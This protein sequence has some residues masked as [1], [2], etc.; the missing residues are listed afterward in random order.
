MRHDGGSLEYATRV[1]LA[2]WVAPHTL[3][4]SRRASRAGDRN[5]NEERIAVETIGKTSGAGESILRRL[6]VRRVVNATGHRTVLG[7]SRMA[8]SAVRAAVAISAEFVDMFELN[9]AVCRR[10]AE[11]TGNEA[12]L[13]TNGAASGLMLAVVAAMADDTVALERLPRRRPARHTVLIHRTHRTP[14]DRSIELAGAEIVEFGNAVETTCAH[15]EAA[16]DERTAAIVYV[17][18]GYYRRGSLDLPTVIAAARRHGT[19]VIVDAA[20]E[21]PPPGNLTAFTRGHGADAAVFSGGKDLRGPQASGLLLGR[22]ALI[23]TA[24][25]AAF[26]HTGIGR[27]MKV[28]KEEL[29]GLL[30]AVEEYVTVDH[31]ARARRSAEIIRGWAQ[32]LADRPGVDCAIDADRAFHGLLIRLSS[33]VTATAAEVRDQLMAGDPAIAVDFV[34]GI[35]GLRVTAHLLTDAEAE[36]VIN[37]LERALDENG[38]AAVEGDT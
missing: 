1:D 37:A 9:A 30:A 18:D 21:L 28:G 22:A 38:P 17:A 2:C 24:R 33:P 13:V 29:V 11:L 32:R 3:K 31:E 16:L 8:E 23:G 10:L 27:P 5:R 4:R 20:G 35:S 34:Q 19:P 36:L 15:L 12:A 26:P 14:L 25:Q 6:E 7:G